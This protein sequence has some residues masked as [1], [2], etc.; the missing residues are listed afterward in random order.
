MTD[1]LAGRLAAQGLDAPW[2]EPLPLAAGVSAVG[3]ASEG[4]E[5]LTWW[6]RLRAV[7]ERIGFWPLL[8]PS[9]DEAVRASGAGEAGPAER[10]A[11]AAQLDGVKLLNPKGTFGSL[12]EQLQ[13]DMLARWPEQPRRIDEFA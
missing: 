13:Q 6:R 3:F 5:A 4:E 8:I 10:L 2:L 9:V 7:N 1:D 11:R 12:D